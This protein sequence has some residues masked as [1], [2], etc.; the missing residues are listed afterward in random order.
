MQSGDFNADHTQTPQ[1]EPV[2]RFSMGS[3]AI[4]PESDCAHP[5]PSL[6]DLMGLTFFFQ[7]TKKSLA[8]EFFSVTLDPSNQFDSI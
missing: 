6:C 8:L 7:K 1:K 5:C 2:V 4:L 3:G